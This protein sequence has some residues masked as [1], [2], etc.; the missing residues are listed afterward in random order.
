MTS[1]RKICCQDSTIIYWCL[2]IVCIIISKKQITHPVQTYS[3]KAV[4]ELN[5][6][7]SNRLVKLCHTKLGRSKS[8]QEEANGT[9]G[10]WALL[11]LPALSH[12]F[13]FFF[14]KL[15]LPAI[16]PLLYWQSGVPADQ[17]RSDCSDVSAAKA[18]LSDTLEQSLGAAPSLRDEGARGTKQAPEGK[19]QERRLHSRAGLWPATQKCVHVAALRHFPHGLF[20]KHHLQH[21]AHVKRT[22]E[23]GRAGASVQNRSTVLRLW[24]QALRYL[25]YL[26]FITSTFG[27]SGLLANFSNVYFIISICTVYSDI[28]FMSCTL[29]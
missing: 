4:K 29:T 27:R 9:E 13:F 17:N 25:Q 14:F 7:V 5:G 10:K 28:S 23:T 21:M 3:I 8:P 19:A 6:D 15:T 12:T 22:G 26:L 20:S 24:T 2:W 16:L 11:A 18:C 1:T